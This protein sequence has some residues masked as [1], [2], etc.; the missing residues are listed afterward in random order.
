MVENLM[1]DLCLNVMQILR[2][3][4]PCSNADVA[5]RLGVSADKTYRAICE[6]TNR[7][8]AIHPKLQRWDLSVQGFRFWDKSPK[9]KLALF[10]SPQS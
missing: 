7:G 9:Q 2:I 3:Y 10:A 6:L 5:R 8:L 4:G 1:S